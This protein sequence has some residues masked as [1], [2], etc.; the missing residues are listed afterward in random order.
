M[1][2]NKL[3]AG[4][5]DGKLYQLWWNDQIVNPEWVWLATPPLET[6]ITSAPGAAIMNSK[7]FVPGEDG[8]LYQLY[9]ESA[10]GWNW[11]D[12]GMPLPDIEITT[13]PT[14]VIGSKVFAGTSSLKLA[15]L[16]WTGYDWTWDPL[17][18]IPNINRVFVLMLEN[19]SFDH[20]LGFSGITGTD[21]VSGQQAVID[22]LTGEESNS[23]IPVEGGAA[24]QMDKDPGHEFKDVVTQLCGK[25]ASYPSGGPYPTINNSGFVSNWTKVNH[26]ADPGQ[27]MECQLESQVPWLTMFA[28]HYA[29]CDNWYSSMPG[30]TWPNRFFVHAASAGGLDDSPSSLK[31]FFGI[32]EGTSFRMAQYMIGLQKSTCGTKSIPALSFHKPSP[33][34][35]LAVSITY[36]I[37]LNI[38]SKM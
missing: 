38:F 13:T 27:I 14:A 16:Y 30:P 2:N 29:I 5:E 32:W 18:D 28:R 7:L 37:S 17:T 4:C 25:G 1:D 36:G 26:D 9:Y 19:R 12:Q 35:E 8:H 33:C 11:T 22:G 20:M 23:G 6:S 21:A 31:Y 15:Q 34:S 3:F 24:W 10:S